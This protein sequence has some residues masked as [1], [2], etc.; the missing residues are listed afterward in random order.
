[1]SRYIDADKLMK[2]LNEVQIENDEYYKGLGK[3][4]LIVYD[5]PTADVGGEWIRMNDKEVCCS[6]CGLIRNITTQEGWNF[7]PKCGMKIQLGE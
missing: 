5:Q 1:M 2:E 6:C 3:A 4:K 7:C